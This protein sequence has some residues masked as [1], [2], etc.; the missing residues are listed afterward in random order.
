MASV[1]RLSHDELLTLGQRAIENSQ[2]VPEIAEAVAVYGYDEAAFA[3]GQA[4]LDVFEATLQ[5]RQD[6]R[7]RKLEASEALEDAWDQLRKDV[8]TPHTSIARGVIF[9]EEATQERLGLNGEQSDDF[10][11]W[12]QEARR[13]YNT[14][15]G[16][17]ELA[18]RAAERGL[19]A[20]LLQEALAEVD[21]LEA[22]DQRQERLKE[23]KDD[24]NRRRKQERRAFANWLSDYQKTAKAALRDRPD[25]VEQLGVSPQ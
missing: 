22:L 1:Y 10:E 17:E 18:A 7:G 12:L 4:L 2:R 13:F 15:L 25:L 16:D 3:R 5:E 19:T 8:F 21:A 6:V 20:S 23:S 14:L 9:K 24:V 11:E